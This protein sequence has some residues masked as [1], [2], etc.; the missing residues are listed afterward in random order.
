VTLGDV[1]NFYAIVSGQARAG[2]LRNPSPELLNVFISAEDEV[3]LI[4]FL[5]SLNEDYK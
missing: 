3:T 5:N 1:L 4:A 2:Q